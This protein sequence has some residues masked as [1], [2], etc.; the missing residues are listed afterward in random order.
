MKYKKYD[1]LGLG[2]LILIFLTPLSAFLYLGWLLAIIIIL[3][4]RVT[5]VCRNRNPNSLIHRTKIWL[6]ADPLNLPHLTLLTAALIATLTSRYH[7]ESVGGLLIFTTYIIT[8]Y[9]ILNWLKE[10]NQIKLV[11]TTLTISAAVVSLLGLCL[12]LS[13]SNFIWS[14]P[15]LQLTV[16]AGRMTGTFSNPNFYATYLVLF[17]PLI[18]ASGFI[19]SSA[20][21]RL[22]IV[23][24]SL[25]MTINLV[26][27]GSRTAWLSLVV[28]LSIFLFL[29]LS[30]YPKRKIKIL[31][32]SLYLGV[33][34]ITFI[35][36]IFLLQ[37]SRVFSFFRLSQDTSLASRLRIWGATL[38]IIRD[39]PWTGTG[40]GT[41]QRVM[42]L[43]LPESP[44]DWHSHA[45]NLYLHLGGEMG[46][47]GAILFIWFFITAFRQIRQIYLSVQNPESRL[48]IIG[49]IAGL[50]GF[51][52][53]TITEVLINNAQ[54]GIM[55]WIMLA[56]IFSIGKIAGRMNFSEPRGR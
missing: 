34:V 6:R 4:R 1:F 42:P 12:Y 31:I 2:L 14:Y 48:L 47:P 24:L 15:L 21:R 33:V 18:V 54:L 25:L 52:M 22:G 49:G 32:L 20:I 30:S 56:I 46:L 38:R 11:L 26:L 37:P 55:F 5:M 41:F 17:L 3:K 53:H 39:H 10:K 9:L 44:R 43:Y 50:G 19:F 7:S 29:A 40:P 27:S 45:H 28:T 23:I 51:F 36:L 16:E 13:R 8:Y 35:S